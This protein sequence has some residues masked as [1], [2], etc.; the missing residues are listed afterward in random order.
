MPLELTGLI[1]SEIRVTL[2]GIGSFPLDKPMLASSHVPKG[3]YQ[4]GYSD[5]QSKGF[6]VKVRKSKRVL[7]IAADHYPFHFVFR[8]PVYSFFPAVDG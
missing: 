4:Y 2:L 3:H 8:T 7:T 6:L 5:R 1:A